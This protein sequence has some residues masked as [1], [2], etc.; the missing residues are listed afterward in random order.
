MLKRTIQLLMI[1]LLMV[2][3]LPWSSSH[4]QGA[5]AQGNEEAA[6]PLTTASVS[7]E[8][9]QPGRALVTARGNHWVIDSVPPLGGPNEEVNPLDSLLAALATC[10][11]F[12]YESAAQELGIP[13]NRLDV[14][15]EGDFAPEGLKD[16]A[17]NPRIRAFRVLIDMDGPTVEQANML[18]EQWKIRC[19]IYTT[20]ER[21]APIEVVHVAQGE[22]AARLLEISF[23]Y[24]GTAQEYEDAVS[25]LADAFAQ[26]N[27]LVWKIWTVNADAKRAGGL[28]LFKN[29]Q[30]LQAFLNSDLA[31]QVTSHPALSDFSIS[32]FSIMGP[33]TATTRGPVTAEAAAAFNRGEPGLALVVNFHYEGT[34][35]DLQDAVSPLAEDYAAIDGMRWKIWSVDAE[36]NE[37]SAILFFDNADAIQAF[38]DGDVAA[39]VMGNPSFS[40]FDVN[41][42][43]VMPAESAVTHGPIGTQ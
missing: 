31:A 18:R 34:V 19:P 12:V 36:K 10:G 28:F 26:T 24:E 30:T 8:L 3:A 15:V 43:N 29:D 6:I 40:N 37:F 33:E 41:V 32:S 11:M 27:G 1:S 35:Q 4:G 20:L 21:A 14:S 13:L 25:P 9:A 42:Y 2:L 5:Q 17:V 16:G 39:Q 38:A 7:A 23:T 22:T